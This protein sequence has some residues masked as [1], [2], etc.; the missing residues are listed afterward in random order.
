MRIAQDVAGERYQNAG[1]FAGSGCFERRQALGFRCQ[2][3]KFD[4]VALVGLAKGCTALGATI[5]INAKEG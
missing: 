5:F 1:Y 4:R 3:R 2:A